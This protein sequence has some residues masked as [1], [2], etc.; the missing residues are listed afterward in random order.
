MSSYADV[1]NVSLN[2]YMSGTIAVGTT[3]YYWFR[4]PTA[5]NGGGITLLS[6]YI[7]EESTAHAVGSAP[8]FR[9][10]RYSGGSTPAVAGTIASFGT[11]TAAGTPLAFTIASPFVDANSWVVVEAGGT[12]ATSVGLNAVVTCNYVMGY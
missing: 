8:I 4:S 9:L 10:L 5:V 7:T 12:V 11:L 1:N 3:N 2:L 6:A